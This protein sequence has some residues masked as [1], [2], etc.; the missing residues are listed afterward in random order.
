METLLLCAIGTPVQCH[1]IN[2]EFFAECPVP[3]ARFLV[4]S[5]PFP[6][7][8]SMRGTTSI[9]SLQQSRTKRLVEEEWLLRQLS[10][11]SKPLHPPERDL[12]IMMDGT[13]LSLVLQ[14]EDHEEKY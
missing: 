11:H 12:R 6:G 2:A 4:L 13:T 14:Q 3:D 9:F 10:L 1:A 8:E 7:H 5:F